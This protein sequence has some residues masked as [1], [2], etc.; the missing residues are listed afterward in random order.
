[1]HY[2]ETPPYTAVCAVGTIIL[3]LKVHLFG[4]PEQ[5]GLMGSYALPVLYFLVFLSP[6][7]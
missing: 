7:L 5:L 1:M 4:L 3:L 2:L 6:G